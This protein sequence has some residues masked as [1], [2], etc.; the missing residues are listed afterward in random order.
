MAQKDLARVANARKAISGQYQG[1]LD[2]AILARKAAEEKS[3]ARQGG[4]R[5]VEGESLRRNAGLH[6]PARGGTTPSRSFERELLP[7]K[8]GD[9]FSSELFHIARLH[10]VR[11]A[12]EKPKPNAERLREYRDFPAAGIA[13]ISSCIRPAPLHHRAGARH[14]AVPARWSYLAEQLG[15]ESQFVVKVLDGKSPAAQATE[16]IAGTKLLDPQG[17]AHRQG[18]RL[19]KST[20][21]AIR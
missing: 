2:P 7:R 1:L 13:R 11:L 5:S 15:G 19:R 18:R 4:G 9:A 21:P 3:A 8:R 12:A 20:L 16:L 17:A 10:P 6:L 14:Q